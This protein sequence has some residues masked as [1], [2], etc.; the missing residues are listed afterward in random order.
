MLRRLTTLCQ[1]K[2][3]LLR[4]IGDRANITAAACVIGDEVLNGKTQD[5]N[6]NYLGKYL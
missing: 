6:A 5:S 4:R 3:L 1:A 2:S